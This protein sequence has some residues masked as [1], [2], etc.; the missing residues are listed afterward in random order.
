[1]LE[2]VNLLELWRTVWSILGPVLTVILLLYVFYPE[3]LEKILI[4]VLKLFSLI[5]DQV[6]KRVVSREVTYIVSTHFAKSFYFEEV[7]KV[8]VKWGEEDEAILD[9]KRNMLVV[10]LRKGRKR[11]HEN[12]ARAL[13]KAIPELLAPEMKV[14]YDLKFVNSL[15]AHIARSLA[16]EYQPVIA[17]INEFIASEIES[18]KALKE[19]ISMLIEIDDQSLFSRILL[20]EL[21]RV[22]RSRYPH[23]DPE[24]DEEVLDLI[25]M[26]HGLVRGEISKPLLCTRYFKILFVRVARPEKIMAALEPHIQ[27][28][29]YAIKGCPAIETIYVLAAGKNIVAAKALKSPL[30]KE[31]ENIGIKCRIISEHE[32]TGTYKGAPHMRLYVCKIELERTMQASTPL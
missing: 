32:Y 23:R 3:K 10:V 21:I 28:V 9:L 30:E 14:V 19:L 4:Q 17:A 18:D 13:L 26:L 24:I 31:L 5:S 8:I 2:E 1:M 7:P 25:K 27:F 29:K 12:I 6:E 16:R 22:A 20:P 11:R 15:S